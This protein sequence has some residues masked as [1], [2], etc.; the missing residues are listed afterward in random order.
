MIFDFEFVGNGFWIVQGPWATLMEID[1]DSRIFKVW[2]KTLKI[3]ESQSISIKVALE[4]WKRPSKLYNQLGNW[5]SIPNIEI[6]CQYVSLH[7]IWC[8]D[9][10]MFGKF[11]FSEVREFSDFLLTFEAAGRSASA[12]SKR[13]L[14]FFGFI[15]IAEKWV[16]T[17]PH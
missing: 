17:G 15:H 14:G 3:L 5:K 2:P 11:V 1:W 16:W 4:P 7:A 10:E 12:E 8:K 13:R 6:S 9:T